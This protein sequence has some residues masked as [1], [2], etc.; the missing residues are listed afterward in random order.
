MLSCLEFLGKP[1]TNITLLFRREPHNYDK[2][3]PTLHQTTIYQQ[4]LAE[5]QKN[6]QMQQHPQHLQQPSLS[7]NTLQHQATVYQPTQQQQQ[8]LQ[9]QQQ[10]NINNTFTQSPHQY[11]TNLLNNTGTYGSSTENIAN[12][13]SGQL[14][15]QN[16]NSNNAPGG[17]AL[18]TS[19]Q[20]STQLNANNQS[21]NNA[22]QNIK[23]EVPSP[24]VLTMFN[25]SQGS[26][27]GY[28]PYKPYNHT[29]NFKKSASTGTYINIRGNQ[30][31]NNQM[32]M[33]Q[34][35]DRSIIVSR[36]YHAHTLITSHIGHTFTWPSKCFAITTPSIITTKYATN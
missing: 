15:G 6:Q 32:Y 16:S 33:Q 25:L 8:Q 30:T 4:M 20:A 24:D 35:H 28:V 31:S 10:Q 34:P 5:Q 13:V 29:G 22:L 1:K 7:S 14:T 27:E 9:Q 18:M 2:A 11:N 19:P 12:M 21:N 23:I 3:Q 36:W 17:Y 26:A